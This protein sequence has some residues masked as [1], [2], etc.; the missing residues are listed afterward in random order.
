MGR[1]YDNDLQEYVS[2]KQLVEDYKMQGFITEK[3]EEW[4]K[5]N[6]FGK[7][8]EGCI[9]EATKKY[10]PDIKIT[11]TTKEYDYVYGADF[12]IGMGDLTCYFDLKTAMA[13][14]V[15][16]CN[17]FLDKNRTFKAKFEDIKFVRIT[18]QG[19]KIVLGIRYS[20]TIKQ[21][22]IFYSKPVLVPIIFGDKMNEETIQTKDFIDNFMFV[23]RI[24]M[25]YLNRRQYSK[26]VVR[27]FG[28]LPHDNA[29]EDC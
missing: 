28:F 23:L 11:K 27:R 17:Y 7:K 19:V 16:K 9:I 13:K 18:P 8:A 22:R 3:H 20:K 25:Q 26:K 5:E 4:R 12:K 14:D 24:G 1:K 29:E 6:P 21:G 15:V 10:R 2:L